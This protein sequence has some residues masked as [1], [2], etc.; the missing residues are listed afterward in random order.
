MKVTAAEQRDLGIVDAVI[1]SP[2]RA[3][4]P[5]RGDGQANQGNR[6]RAARRAGS[7]SIDDLVEARYKR[8]RAYGPYTVADR[9]AAP[10]ERVGIAD[11]LR[12]LLA[13]RPSMPPFAGRGAPA[14]RVGRRSRRCRSS[15]GCGFWRQ[16]P[17]GRSR[18]RRGPRVHRRL[19][20][21]FCG[22]DRP[23]RGQRPARDR[24]PRGRLEGQAT[25]AAP[26]GDPRR[27]AMVGVEAH[28]GSG[29]AAGRGALPTADPT[30]E[31]VIRAWKMS[32]GGAGPDCGQVP[33]C[34]HLSPTPGPR[35]WNARPLRRPDRVRRRLGVH[36]EWSRPLTAPSAPAW[37]R[38]AR[39]WNT[40]RI[41]SG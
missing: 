1:P 3:P 31:T 32:R 8:Y 21:T 6:A 26:T 9:P 7:H 41:S 34:G 33:G 30:I 28:A 38:P 22:A 19:A 10:P 13:A 24:G 35:G 5:T 25:Q 23:A 11:R 17:S 18:A 29:Y 37:P 16:R 14:R 40:G 36:Q 27:I 12:G 39:R 20:T 4:T 2:A 15:R